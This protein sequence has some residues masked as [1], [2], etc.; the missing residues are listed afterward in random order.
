[1]VVD[2]SEPSE[3][4]QMKINEVMTPD[5][6]CCTASDSA[7]KAAMIMRELNVGIVPIVADGD[8]NQLLGVVT[9]RDLCMSV[10]AEGKDPKAIRLENCMSKELVTCT[11]DDEVEEV[12]HLMQE[13]QVRRIPVVG[14]DNRIQGIVSIADMVLGSDI[15][16]EEIDETIRDISEPDLNEFKQLTHLDAAGND[17]NK[18]LDIDEQS[19][20]KRGS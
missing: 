2:A 11:A 19:S 17:G 7:N 12:L 18:L 4:L 9:D 1:M 10:V 5:P 16:S 14:Q 3:G 6:A 20:K 15:G 8:S 13:N